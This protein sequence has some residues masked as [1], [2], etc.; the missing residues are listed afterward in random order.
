MNKGNFVLMLHAH[1]PFI[2]HP[3]FPQFLEERWLFEG[4]TETYIPLLK[5]FERLEKDGVNFRLAMSITPPL[6]EMFANKDLQRKYEEYMNKL[7]ELADKEIERTK[8]EDPLKHKMAKFY[9]E[10]YEDILGHFK[11]V[12]GDLT[13][14]FA[15]FQSK[16]YLQIIT[17]NATHG[18]LPLMMHIPQN[19]NAQIEVGFNAYKKHVGQNPEGIWLAECGYEQGLDKYLKRNGLSF[20]FVDSHGLWFGDPA[21]AYGVYRPVM[22]EEGVFVFARD[23]ESSQQ[24]WSADVGYPGDSRY[25]EFYRDIGFDRE[26]HYIKPYIDGSGERCNTGIKYHKITSK[27]N[28]LNSKELYDIEEA[29]EAVREHARDFI[30]KKKEQVAKLLEEFDGVAPV[31]TAPFDAELFGHWWYEGPLFIEQLFREMDKADELNPHTPREVI[32]TL[33]S[34]QIVTPA[35]STWGAN[36]YN[37][38]WLNGSNEWIYRHLDSAAENM[39]NLSK[40]YYHANRLQERVLNQMARELLLAQSS[41][42][43][44]IMTT[45]TT[46]EYAVN[47]TKTHLNRFRELKKELENDNIDENKLKTLEWIDSIFSNID[48]RVYAKEL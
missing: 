7:I 45:G 11:A 1:L 32:D 10:D 46:V 13:K 28:D 41:D 20:F 25:R 43:A 23:P 12:D 38:V 6:M 34:V 39:I 22:T 42:W 24:V 5:A 3:D 4:I 35:A 14:A 18:L 33:D 17:C 2:N 47:K 8:G 40:K 48:F 9:R 36:G 27:K 16:G 29:Y 44:F 31:I 21:P 15:H 37:E 30:N 26:E 19:V